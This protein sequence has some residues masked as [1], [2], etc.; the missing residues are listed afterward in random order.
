M[1]IYRLGWL[2]GTSLLAFSAPVLAQTSISTTT[3]DVAATAA[4]ANNTVDAVVVTGA[5]RT[6]RLQEVPLAVTSISGDDFAA[7][8]FK[9]PKELTYLSPSIQISQGGNGI[10]IRGSGTNSQNAGTEQSVG[11]VIDGVLMGFVDDIGGDTSD[12]DH[13]EV[14]RGPQGTQFAKNA[15]AGVVSITTKKPEIGANLW[16]T[17]IAYG[18]HNDTNANSVLN[19]PIN[20]TM[21]ARFSASFQHRDGV[22]YNAA[23]K[24]YQGGREA[25]G[26]RGKFIWKPKDRTSIY[27][28]VDVRREVYNPNFPQAFQ[29]CG[30]GSNATFN[31][32]FG[33]P[34]APKALP[35]C[36]GVIAEGVVPGPDNTVSGEMDPAFRHTVAGGSSVQIEYPL[37]EFEL[38]SLTAFRFMSRRFHGPSGS[39]S[40]SSQFL[41]NSYNAFQWSEEL[42]LVSPPSEK[43][44][45]VL[46]LFL[47]DRV[48]HL[49]TLTAGQGYG[50]VFTVPAAVAYGPLAVVSSSGGELFSNNFNKSV[51]GYAD[52][53]YHFTSKLQAVAG[54]RVTRDMVS[55][56]GHTVVLPGVFLSPGAVFKPSDAD[57]ITKTGVTARIGPQ[58]FFTPDV[59][60]YGTYAHGYK[61]PIID[62]STAV[63]GRVLPETVNAF[64]TGIKSAWL[65]HRL[66]VDVTAFNENFKNYQVSTLNTSIVPNVFQLGNAGGQLSR[67]VEL[68]INAK[69]VS[70]ISMQF[71][72]TYLDS[73]YTEF[74]TACYTT[75]AQLATSTQTYKE[76]QITDPSGKGGCYSFTSGTSTVRYTD[77]AGFPLIN[78]SKWTYRF[79][80]NYNHPVEGG[81]TIDASATY[82]WRS[83]FYSV[84]PDPNLVNRPYGLANFTLG[85]TSPDGRWRMGFWVRNAFNKFF[86][87][88]IQANTSDGGVGGATNVLPTE[89]VRT[90]GVSLDV[91]L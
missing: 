25:Y 55:A 23:L 43:F 15:S 30:P 18:E 66:T 16:D 26:L 42:R 54:I 48:S 53:T 19:V 89:A 86:T 46:G 4:G 58:Y 82:L 78:A 22:F 31:T 12:L 87:L 79:G 2:A 72:L 65:Q 5:L 44:D 57:E 3:A 77:A 62:T 1:R 68:E 35:P 37:G 73:H 32:V 64:E 69:P 27:W 7:S 6:Q 85:Y 24:D 33:T 56:D 45:Y 70:S 90:A 20:D 91:K 36:V 52:G 81:G 17:H 38:T 71:G 28:S 84:A 49:K 67:G 60:V 50:S 83:K 61:G 88:A 21:A 39:G 8:N 51:A 9:E 34:S 10:Y 75:P 59:Q 13:I 14:Y 41:N 74:R 11:M 63:F 47:Y 76:P 80:L 40:Y 29:K